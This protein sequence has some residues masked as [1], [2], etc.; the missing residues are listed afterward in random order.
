[1]INDMQASFA[2]IT[3][4]LLDHHTTLAEEEGKQVVVLSTTDMRFIL[5]FV[6]KLILFYNENTGDN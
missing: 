4:A 1:M 2:A 3:L 6:E 5:N